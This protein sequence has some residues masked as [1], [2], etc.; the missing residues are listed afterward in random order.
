MAVGEDAVA[1]GDN[2]LRRGRNQRLRQAVHRHR[3]VTRQGLQERLFTLAFSGLVYPQIWEDPIVDLEAL[4]LREDEHLVAIASGGCNVFSYLATVPVLVTAIDLN[5]AHVALNRLKLAALRY[6]PDYDA[7]RSF[8]VDADSKD[9]VE[10]YF[11]YLRDHLD[12]QTRKYW[13][14]RDRL[15]RQRIG[16][17]ATNFYRHGLLGNFIAAGH[18]L[19][20]LHGKDPRRVLEA[21]SMAEQRT[22]FDSELAPLFEKRH[23]RWLL[24]KPSALFGLGIPPSQFDALKGGADSMADVLRARLE[25][26]ACGFDLKEN[27]FAWQAFGR[28]YSTATDAPL[29]PYLHRQGFEKLRRRASD[30]NVVHA[31]FTEHLAASPA[32]S[33]DAYVLLDAQDWMT[34]EQLGAL[35]SEIVRT[36][37]PGARVIFRTAGE[38]TILP[39]RV[40]DAILSR[41]SYDRDYGRTLTEKDRSSIYGGF[42]LYTLNA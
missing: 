18:K 25:R 9:N 40:P 15:G 6:L 13:E 36:G 31:S 30:L 2:G 39:G 11:D 1:R 8:F 29:P 26:L 5:P 37:R 4:N 14:S 38:E 7:F 16:Y 12:P 35:W 3:A 17:F 24:N 28:R 10:A 41:F 27:Y 34:D 20:R 32:A 42:H 22:L 19:A 23:I 33:C 21:K